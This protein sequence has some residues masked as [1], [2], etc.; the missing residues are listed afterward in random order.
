MRRVS[1]SRLL[2]WEACDNVREVGGYPTVDGRTTRWGALVKSD[3]L[4]RL[5]E[6]GR[7]SLV[8]YGIRTVVDLRFPEQV[9][10]DGPHPFAGGKHDGISVH[11]VHAPINFGSDSQNQRARDGVRGVEI[12]TVGQIYAH[13]IDFF[14]DRVAAAVR[15]IVFAPRGGVVVHCS[16]G[17]DRTGTLAAIVL[18]ALGVPEEVIVEDYLVMPQD[19]RAE[20]EDQRRLWDATPPSEREGLDRFGPEAM[21]DFLV[22]LTERHGGATTLL[23]SAGVSDEEL[24]SLRERLSEPCG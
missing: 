10:A 13:T 19:R 8:A 2:D 11:Y 21:Q 6:T 12:K 16:G 4:T 9:R 17:W 20:Y 7:K 23:R 3:T 14:A 15:A 1:G 5:S 18:A 22:H 24:A